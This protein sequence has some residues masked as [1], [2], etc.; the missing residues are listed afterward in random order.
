MYDENYLIQNGVDVTKSLELF[1]DI[2]TYNEIVGEF[3]VSA[4]EKQAKLQKY[5]DEKDMAN[6]TIYVHSLKS[7]AKYF[8]FTKLATMAEE[9]EQKS[10]EG[11]VFFIYE[12]FQA[13]IDEIQ[14]MMLVVKKYL[15]PE[16]QTPQTSQTA[17]QV[18]SMPDSQTVATAPAENL[19]EPYTQKTILVADDSNIIRNFV[20]RIFSEKYNVGV[21]QDGEEALKIIKANQNN[22]EIVAVLLDLNMPRV[23]GFAV[24]DF[25]NNNQLFSK[26][27]VSIISGDS[28]K[29][30]I[31]KAFGYQIVDMLAKPFTEMDI[32]HVVEKTIYFKNID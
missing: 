16:T 11:D 17:T 8:G 20:K 22:E 31:A 28:S 24:L 6:Y 29:D 23:D 27:P 18:V 10:K 2:N 32:K 25:M 14:R 1:G 4:K 13:L 30:T 26:M 5:K 3:L 15:Y 12:N 19:P 9:Q 21:A 7:D